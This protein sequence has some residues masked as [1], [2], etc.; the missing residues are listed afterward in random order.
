MPD[1]HRS[2]ERGSRRLDLDPRFTRFLVCMV[3]ALFVGHFTYYVASV[4]PT[5]RDFA[6]V[7]YAARAVLSGANPY[8]VI[9]RLRTFHWPWPFYYPLPAA[10]LAIPLAPLPEH[11]AMSVVGFIGAGVLAWALTE[12][13]YVGLVAFFSYSVWQAFNLV[14]WS[15]LLTGA[16]VLAPLSIILVAKPTIG[17]AV[18]A[19]RPT[20]WAIGGAIVLTGVA[21]IVQPHWVSDWRMALLSTHVQPGKEFH[22]AAPVMLPGGVLALAA[23][24]RWRRPEARLLAAMACVP[25]TM[26]PYEAVPLFLIPRGKLQTIAFVLLNHAVWMVARLAGPH[27]DFAA[28]TTTYGRALVCLMYLPATLMVLRRP[29]EGDA[30]TLV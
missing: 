12:H 28:L 4:S 5:H 10:I 17:A 18:F 20:W 21:F 26:L 15:P 7:W 19:A 1:A 27:E 22:S 23:L 8:E 11:V 25:Q 24:A 2:R 13:G 9:G 3:I 16:V 30:P 14:Q 6:Q 29:N